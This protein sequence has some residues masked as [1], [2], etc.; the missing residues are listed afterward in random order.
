M[1]TRTHNT[2]KRTHARTHA[3][4]HTHTHSVSHTYLGK[5]L[6]CN[7]QLVLDPLLHKHKRLSF[8]HYQEEGVPKGVDLEAHI[9]Q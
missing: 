8:L 7:L 1:H 9:G 2:H 6:I 3:R 4:T 5:L